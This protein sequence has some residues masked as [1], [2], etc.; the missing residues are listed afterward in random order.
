[1]EVETEE[2]E[3]AAE[4]ETV[5]ETKAAAVIDSAVRMMRRI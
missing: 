4:A 3:A 2:A 1:M 5:A